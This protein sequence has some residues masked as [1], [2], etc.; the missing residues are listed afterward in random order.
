[1]IMTIE[2]LR[3]LKENLEILAD[4]RDPKSGYKVED[5]ILKSKFNKRILQDAA[6]VIEELLKVDF[7]PYKIDKRKKFTFFLSKAEKE[8]IEIS[9]VPISISMFTYNINEHIDSHRM[10]KLKAEQITS[11]LMNKGYLEKYENEEGKTF[12]VLTDKSDSIGITTEKRT[13]KYGNTY[14]VNLYNKNAQKFIIEN[15][16]EISKTNSPLLK[17]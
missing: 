11:W 6:N 15:L 10:K 8:K 4:E 5:T 1:M 17:E 12:K 3:L 9:D 7:N 13:S 2:N 14:P 16:D